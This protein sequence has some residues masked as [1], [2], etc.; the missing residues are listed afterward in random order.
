MTEEVYHCHHKH[1]PPHKILSELFPASWNWTITGIDLRVLLWQ[2]RILVD[3]SAKPDATLQSV[4]TRR[5]IQNSTTESGQN[6][7]GQKSDKG[8]GLLGRGVLG[9]DACPQPNGAS[10]PGEAPLR[11]ETGL[12]LEYGWDAMRTSHHAISLQTLMEG[13]Q[14]AA[15]SLAIHTSNASGAFHYAL[16][17][18]R[19]K[20]HTVHAPLMTSNFYLISWRDWN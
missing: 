2:F 7:R 20:M 10:W 6:F 11:C 16:A 13:K 12:S 5:A 17:T 18:T 8:Q 3:R 1:Y 14:S 9:G 15:A 19:Y 4:L